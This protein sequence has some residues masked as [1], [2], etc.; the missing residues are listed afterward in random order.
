MSRI[1]VGA[2]LSLAAGASASIDFS[3][4]GGGIALQN[5]QEILGSE[6]NPLFDVTTD[7]AGGLAIFDTT[8]PGP[9]SAGNDPDLLVNLGN[10]L[11]MQ[12]NNIQTQT[13]PGIFDTPNDEGSG[14]N[15]TFSFLAAT[16]LASV[17]LI[18]MN[19]GNGGTVTLT[20]AG[21]N[22]RVFD[23]PQMWTNDIDSEGPLGF[24]VID[25]AELGPQT[26]DTSVEVTVTQNDA[27][28]DLSQV[29]ELN[30]FF[31]GSGAVDN[32][33]IIPAPGT[34]ALAFAGMGF[35]ARRRRG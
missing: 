13:T 27:G 5:G 14:G 6:F 8:D 26:A 15:I 21:G 10:A 2:V 18:D 29:V 28:F 11:I 7:A 32:L 20:D 4:D 33:E 12:E 25:F 19:G 30:I 34:V 9:N 31:V 17:T 1:A 24:G 23:V 3:V 35:A 22:V 16:E